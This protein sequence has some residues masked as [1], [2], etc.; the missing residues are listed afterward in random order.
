M[1]GSGDPPLPSLNQPI[2]SIQV[3]QTPTDDM[4]Q[5]TGPS[6]CTRSAS[7]TPLQSKDHGI[8]K[9]PEKRSFGM[10]SDELYSEG[11]DSDGQRAPWEGVIVEDYE[12]EELI[13]VEEDIQN[14]DTATSDPPVT[15]PNPT[16]LTEEMVDRMKVTELKDH[17]KRRGASIK[18]KKAELIKRLKEAIRNN[19][20]L[21]SE[22]NAEDV[23]NLVGDEFDPGARQ[24]LLEPDEEEVVE[25]EILEVDGVTFHGPTSDGA[26]KGA[27]RYNYGE[28]FDRLP[29]T[30]QAKQPKKW[31]NGRIAVDR[32][33]RVMYE[34]REHTDTIPNIDFCEEHGLNLDTHPAK[35]FEA[36][37][38]IKNLRRGGGAGMLPFSMESCLSWTNTKARMLNAGLGGKYND[39]VDFTL[40]ELMQHTAL[41]LVQGLSPSPQVAMKFESQVDD[42]INGNDLVHRV[43]GGK[44]SMAVRRHKHF[45]AFFACVDPLIPTPSRDTHPNWK[46]HPLLKH[47]NNV[48]MKAV[49]LG[50]DLSCDEQTVGFQGSHRDKQRITYKK[51]GDGFMAD[52]ICSNGYTYNFHFRHQPASEKLIKEGLSPLHS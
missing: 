36:F 9:T 16:V 15:S 19:V 28:T 40:D 43:F 22:M 35:W 11:Y 34:V 47:M 30:G 37:L 45:K 1:E 3:A 49:H 14:D 17:L 6:M 21:V 29:F 26:E 24:E 10:V 46:I 27:K 20:P 31:R 5:L 18:G 13:A 51:E 25:E 50:R 33:D 42:P 8:P 44:S 38:P 32:N 41:Y 48:S 23:Q 2:E 7:R 4:S 12:E 52:C 39:Y